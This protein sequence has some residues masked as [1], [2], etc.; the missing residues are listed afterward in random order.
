MAPPIALQNS[1]SP[2]S[3][4]I[5]AIILA[6]GRGR[7]LGNPTPKA[8]LEFGGKTLLERHI[9]ALH[10]HGIYDIS[11]TVGYESEAIRREIHRLRLCD[12][13]A[14][15]HNPR[16]EQGSIV[17]LWV[18][19][20]RLIS[21]TSI[22][23]MDADVLYDPRIIGR[24][25]AA[26]APNVLLLDR[27]TEPGD[28]PVKICSRDGVLVDFAKKPIHAHDWHGESVGF[29]RFTAAAAAALAD[30]ADEYVRTGRRFAEYEE[31]IRDIIL[32]EPTRF[33]YEDISDMSWIEIDFDV[34]VTRART[35]ILPRLGDLADA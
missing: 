35:E 22:V 23:L 11:I 16:Y 32:A 27:R 12:G 5:K 15:I 29:F 3:P 25:L 30:R 26:R 19:R 17:S 4:P 1:V 7:R 8:L 20:D 33:G 24:L 6:A 21:G 18:Q 14:L 31:A 13:L 9:A 10:A 34:D 2:K 28:E